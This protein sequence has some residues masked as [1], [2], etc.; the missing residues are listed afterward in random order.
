MAFKCQ[1]KAQR[2]EE[3]INKEVDK[4]SKAALDALNGDCKIRGLTNKTYHEMGIIPSDRTL[5][6]WGKSKLKGVDFREV[7]RSLVLAG[8]EINITLSKEGITI[9]NVQSPPRKS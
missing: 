7:F 1:S 8:Y 3:K 9:G 6:N 4:I 5:T 2:L